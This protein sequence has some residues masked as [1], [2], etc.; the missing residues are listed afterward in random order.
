MRLHFIYAVM[1]AAQYNLGKINL[2][3][4]EFV[5]S[6][7][8]LQSS[9]ATHKLVYGV[10]DKRTMRAHL[11]AVV[12]ARLAGNIKHAKEV[13]E[14]AEETLLGKRSLKVYLRMGIVLS[15]IIVFCGWPWVY[16]HFYPHYMNR[17]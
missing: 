7:H 12:A 13:L 11:G 15:I 8:H 14:K 4:E 17:M 1:A 2:E 5:D 3:L 6:Q 9:F 10:K 16:I